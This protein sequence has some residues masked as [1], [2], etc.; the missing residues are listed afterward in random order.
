MRSLAIIVVLVGLSLAFLSG[1]GDDIFTQG[2]TTMVGLE[3]RIEWG[4]RCGT[5][6]PDGEALRMV[7]AAL[8]NGRP[9]RQT[10]R[11]IEVPVLFHVIYSVDDQG[12]EVG[13]VPIRR[14]EAQIDVLNDAYDDFRFTLAGVDEVYSPDWFER[15]FQR[16]KEMKRALAV[17]PETTLNVYTCVPR[18][19]PYLLLGFST[20][21]WSY[22]EGDPRHGVVLLH[23]SLPGGASVPYNEGDTATHEI[24]HYLGLLH[25]FQNGCKDPGDQVDDTPSEAMAAFYCPNGRDTCPEEGEDPIHNFMDYTDDWCMNHF[26]PL[27]GERMV[28]V[29]EE[30]RP[31]LAAH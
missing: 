1:A 23:S 7:E 9:H 10:V 8:Q 4:L 6:S 11:A 21:P 19:G 3:G 28:A 17:S 29:V 12:A 5:P 20:F 22:P 30:Y 18:Y 2:Q 16:E 26:T 24:G 13:R 25:T 15:C 27:Q 14:L 31:A